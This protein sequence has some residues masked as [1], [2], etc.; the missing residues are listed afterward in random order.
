MSIKFEIIG[1]SLLVYLNGD[2]YDKISK[3]ESEKFSFFWEPAGSGDYIINQLSDLSSD[4]F[5]DGLGFHEFYSSEAFDNLSWIGLF[6][7]GDRLEVSYSVVFEYKEWQNPF[8]VSSLIDPY[9]RRLQ[10]LG[11]RVDVTDDEQ[12]ISV[13]AHA[14]LESEVIIRAIEQFAEIAKSE[15]LKLE[16]ELIKDTNSGLV[17]K[18]FK[19]PKGFETICSQYVLW[20]GELLE[21]IGIEA[22]VSAENRGGHT[23]LTIDPGDD[24]RLK[25]NIERVLYQYLS[26]PYS[27]YVPAETARQDIEK[28][29]FIQSLQQQVSFFE[30]QLEVKKSVMEL[31]CLTNEKLKADLAAANQKTLLLESMQNGRIDILEGAVSIKEYSIGPIVINPKKLLKLIGV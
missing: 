3:D 15:Y 23:F 9:K 26:L 11:Y 13:N 20:F 27:E 4:E 7:K 2:L 21:N 22:N 24:G 19:F 1:D 6:K 30:Q 29:V 18:I 10:E 5:P 12:D 8:K 31:Q 17:T 14:E 16:N 28:K 25:E